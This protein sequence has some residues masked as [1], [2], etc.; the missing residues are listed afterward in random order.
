MINEELE[1]EVEEEVINSRFKNKQ[2]Q[3]QIK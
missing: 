2:L 1:E 3:Y